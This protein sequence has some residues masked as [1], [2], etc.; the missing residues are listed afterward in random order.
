MITLFFCLLNN[1]IIH[2]TNNEDI[3]DRNLLLWRSR[4]EEERK[5]ERK[6]NQEMNRED[7]RK[8]NR[9]RSR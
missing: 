4:G 6:E 2:S 7:K 9:E 1:K 8:I 3:T 5:K